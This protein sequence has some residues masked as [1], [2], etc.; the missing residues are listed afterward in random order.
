MRDKAYCELLGDTFS[1]TYFPLRISKFNCPRGNCEED[2]KVYCTE[3]NPDNPVLCPVFTKL[4]QLVK[5]GS[6]KK[7]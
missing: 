3:M 5:K 7:K 4:E 2:D 6:M 1:V